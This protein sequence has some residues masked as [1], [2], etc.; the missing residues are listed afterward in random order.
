[1]SERRVVFEIRFAT[2]S[3]FCATLA[4]AIRARMA[5]KLLV[6]LCLRLKFAEFL[7]PRLEGEC[8]VCLLLLDLGDRCFLS[9]AGRLKS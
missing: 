2:V 6:E 8:S 9:T 3:S 1:M 7:L 5:W 4:S